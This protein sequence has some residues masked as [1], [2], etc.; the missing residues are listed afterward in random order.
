MTRHAVLAAAFLLYGVV[1]GHGHTPYFVA[2]AL[3]AIYNETTG[4]L[5]HFKRGD[6]HMPEWVIGLIIL[7]AG[8][9]IGAT[10]AH[11]NRK[12]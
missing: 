6:E 2:L 8:I 9:L 1:L 12:P 7:A 10:L 11:F 5:A 3:A 4:A